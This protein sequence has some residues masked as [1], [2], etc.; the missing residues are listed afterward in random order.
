MRYLKVYFLALTVITLASC[1]SNDDTTK[2]GNWIRKAEYNGNARQDAACFVIG[3]TAYVGTGQGIGSDNTLHALNDFWKYDPS[4]DTWT[5]MAALGPDGV[6]VNG[7]VNDYARYGAAGFAVG[8][9]GYISTGY[10]N[11]LAVGNYLPVKDTWEFDPATNSWLKKADFPGNAR[12]HAVAFALGNFGYVGTGT[13]GSNTN[14]ADFYKFTPGAA[15]SL[16]SWTAADGLKDKRSA[17]VA[18]VIKDSAYVVTGS[19][20]GTTPITR[21]YVYD[22]NKDQWN[23]RWQITNATDG[24]FDDDYTTIVRSGAVAFVIKNKAYVATGTAN[25]TWEYDPITGHW[26]EKTTFDGTSRSGAVGF[27]V[28]DR[29][30]VGLGGQSTSSLLDDLREFDPTVE[31]STNDN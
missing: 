10:S 16:G 23:E 28:K 26:T 13:T 11:T 14:F 30:F 19:S 6:D 5:A 29:G 8:T 25:N 3:D 20:T 21:M 1:T 7:A 27:S 22:A 9:K 17:A 4:K 24:S 2:L 12:Y 31:N 18:F 15:G